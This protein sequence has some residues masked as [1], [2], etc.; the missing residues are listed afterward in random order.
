M[1]LN[2]DAKTKNVANHPVSDDLLTVIKMKSTKR[3][4][5]DGEVVMRGYTMFK[6]THKGEDVIYRSSEKYRDRK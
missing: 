2:W 1:T 5:G 3:N 4:T 6:K